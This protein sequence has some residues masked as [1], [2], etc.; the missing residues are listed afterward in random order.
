MD[1]T[2][3]NPSLWG[4]GGES[5]FNAGAAGGTPGLSNLTPALWG[6]GGEAAFNAGASG[7][8]SFLSNPLGYLSQNPGLLLAAAPLAANL[9]MG[10]Q[11][12]PAEGTLQDQAASEASVGNTLSAYGLSGTLPSGLQDALNMNENAGIASVESQYG[13]L[14]LA[15]STME[16]QAEQQIKEATAA[17]Q[18]T[19][20]NQLLAQG[21]QYTGMSQS[22][23]TSLMQTQ[24]AQETA[25]QSA[26][27][28]FSGALA[29]FAFK[30]AA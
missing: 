16:G 30:Q 17:Q 1:L 26:I 24:L 23:L 27:G 20:A 15:G 12:L 4:G 29:G 7:G 21:A 13:K 25:L 14:G 28:S 22:A 2:S 11:P 18:A 5:A 19:L 8:S 10:N 3:L 6:G 9:L